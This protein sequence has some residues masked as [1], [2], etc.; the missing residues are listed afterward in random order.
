MALSRKFQHFCPVARALE[1][2]GDK[3]SLLIVR[4]LLRGPQRFTDLIHSLSSI[5]PSWLTQRLREL[6]TT[7]IVERDRQPGRREV[8]YR[9]T[10]AGRDLLP[11]VEALSLWGLRHAM[12]PPSPG[13]VVHPELLMYGFTSVLNRRQRRLSQAVHWSIHFPLVTYTIS[14]DEDQWSYRKGEEPAADVMVR[15]TPEAW[16]TLVA[17]RGDERSRLFEELPIQGKPERI[18]EFRQLF[19]IRNRACSPGGKMVA[20][21]GE[22]ENADAVPA[23]KKLFCE[24]G[25]ATR[26]GDDSRNLHRR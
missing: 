22:E 18:A 1:R 25:P 8:W 14:F 23:A 15:T 6:E 9:L 12:R 16:G 20:G 10:P 3:W 7:G 5:T 24:S 4:D 17:V 19:G 13:E 26:F 11:V 2:I 21:A